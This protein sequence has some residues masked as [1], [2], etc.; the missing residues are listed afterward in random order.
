MRVTNTGAGAGGRHQGSDLGPT[1]GELGFEV[2]REGRGGG[3]C[4]LEVGDAGA[5]EGEGL[6]GPHE[7]TELAVHDGLCRA[8]RGGTGDVDGVHS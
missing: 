3:L 4:T 8:R 5:G 2:L 6:L 1:G 7:L